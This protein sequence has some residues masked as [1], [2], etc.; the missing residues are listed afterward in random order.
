MN[1][2][3]EELSGLRIDR[4]RLM[5][6]IFELG[7]IGALD[8]GGVCRLALS[9]EDRQARDLVI[10]WMR[11]LDLDISTDSI[12]N[13]LAV[14]PGTG[15]GLPV[16][17]GSHIDSVAT[18]GLY[19]GVLGVLAGLE[20]IETLNKAEVSLASPVAVAAFTNEEGARFAPD[21]MGSGVHQGALDL[22]EMLAVRGIDGITVSDALNSI[23]Y[24]GPTPV[25]SFRAACF[26]ELHVEQG[27]VLEEAGLTIGAVTGVQGIS[28]TEFRITGVSNHA[29]TTPMR[30]RHDAGYV[31]A[32]IAVKA[33]EIAT[34]I[35]GSQVATVGVNEL[36]PNLVNVIADQALVTVDLRNTDENSLQESETRMTEFV[37]DLAARE[38]VKV[39]TRKLARFAP[40]AFDDQ[41]ISLVESKARMLGHS[42]QRLPSGAG[43]DAQMFAPNCPTAMIFVPSKDGISHN[44]HEHTEPDHIEAGVNV[45]L[46]SVLA[47]AS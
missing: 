22:E 33:R 17:M 41:M 30:L 39:E 9:D 14:R 36:Q 32:A 21:M 26:F 15:D 31:A 12:G 11:A 43:H 18:G 38:G 4:D 28:W 44:I 45:L 5:A 24:V 8:G 34:K 35:G 1:E 10:S 13:I 20:I 23:G 16:T 40:V 29:G 46:H 3:A 27:P 47:Q 25:N 7:K 2:L 42:V 37:N 19:D 6:R